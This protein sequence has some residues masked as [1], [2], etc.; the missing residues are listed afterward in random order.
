MP[1]GLERL[2]EACRPFY[3]FLLERA[4]GAQGADRA[5]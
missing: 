3:D 1:P 5:D 2:L 4:V